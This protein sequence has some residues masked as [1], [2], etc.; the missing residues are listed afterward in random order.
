MIAIHH[1]QRVDTARESALELIDAVK[2]WDRQDVTHLLE[3]V[4]LPAVAV[5]LA[6]MVDDEQPL[7]DLLAWVDQRDDVVEGWAWD[8]VRAAHAQ[9]EL[10]RSR[11]ISVPPDVR[12]GQRIYD[13]VRARRRRQAA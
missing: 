6:A 13:R 5:V 7:H 11:K 2:R 8:D 4:D 3:T 10:C 1:D 12:E 9:Y